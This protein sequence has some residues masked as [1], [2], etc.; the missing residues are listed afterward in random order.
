MIATTQ[1]LTTLSDTNFSVCLANG[2]P[3]GLYEHKDLLWP[4]PYGKAY[5]P[6]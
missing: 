1:P 3:L 6:L 5:R 4:L 2:L